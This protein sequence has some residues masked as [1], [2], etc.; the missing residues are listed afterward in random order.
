MIF[1]GCLLASDI[2][3]TLAEKDKVCDRT[4]QAIRYFMD[5]GGR[6]AIAT[7]RHQLTAKWAYEL[8]ASNSPAVTFGC[9]VYDYTERQFVY[10][11]YIPDHV[12]K[13]YF[14]LLK[15]FPGIGSNVFVGDEIYSVQDNEAA[16]LYREYMQGIMGKPFLSVDRDELLGKSWIKINFF[17][18][19]SAKLDSFIDYCDSLNIPD[20]NGT[21]SEKWIYE[22]GSGKDADKGSAL[23]CLARH[24]GI[25]DDHVF[26]IG[27][28]YNDLPMLERA[29]V[30]ATVAN[31]PD[32]IKKAA[33]VVF[34]SCSEGG[35]ADFVEYIERRMR[36]R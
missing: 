5:N 10:A 3:H 24:L 8:T 13:V 11:K 20:F 30:G 18:G 12:K 21:K 36:N 28:F 33:D 15:K 23:M 14:E 4:K 25:G 19:D 16:V 26:A 22:V 6:F 35:V 27:D 32:D 17:D 31:A 1:E 9:A 7:G 2:D 34:S 29:A